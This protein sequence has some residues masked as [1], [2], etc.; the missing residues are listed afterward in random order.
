MSFSVA[1]SRNCVLAVG[2]R[3]LGNDE[4]LD[5]GC[6]LSPAS[7]SVIEPVTKGVEDVAKRDDG[8]A[9]VPTAPPGMA[10]A[11]EGVSVKR[12]GKFVPEKNWQPALAG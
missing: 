3:D 9:V 2:L 10:S 5:Y 11:S 4:D 1:H 6:M 8:G 12:K 7:S